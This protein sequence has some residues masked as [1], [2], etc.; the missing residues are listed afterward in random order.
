MRRSFFYMLLCFL[1][2]PVLAPA[3]DPVFSVVG[4]GSGVRVGQV[5][6]DVA[7]QTLDGKQ[8]RLSDYRDKVVMLNFWAT[9]CPPCRAEMPSMARLHTAMAGEDFVLLALNAEENGEEDVANFL[10]KHPQGFPIVFDMEGRAQAA[11]GVYRFPETFII[12]KDGTILNRVIGGREWDNRNIIEYLK[13][14]A[15]G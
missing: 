15:R 10:K 2:L 6:P 7:L 5:A 8:V 1:L 9:W 12:N 4:S 3:A 14:L 13:F 11:F